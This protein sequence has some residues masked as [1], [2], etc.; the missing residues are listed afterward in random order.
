MTDR[1]L[2]ET[3]VRTAQVA[4]QV[5]A[6]LAV[7]VRDA[8][9]RL[10]AGDLEGGI[11]RVDE[12]LP[13]VERFLTFVAIARDLVRPVAPD[14]AARLDEV[15]GR[16]LAAGERLASALE[17]EDFVAATMT[18][19]LALAPALSAYGPMAEEV[20]WALDTCAAEDAPQA[21]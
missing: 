5:C 13:R 17:G 1:R 18:L 12:L 14:L 9:Q 3:A 15:V 6:A 7:A 21:A 2:A 16:S 4:E 19:E 11:R 20:L 8:G 10:G